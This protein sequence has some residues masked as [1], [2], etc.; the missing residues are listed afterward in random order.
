MTPKRR[1]F[2]QSALAPATH[3]E[4]GMIVSVFVPESFWKNA[5]H[6]V[7][8]GLLDPKPLPWPFRLWWRRPALLLSKIVG[9]KSV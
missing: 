8:V 5:T 2:I 3:G 9:L 7:D 6:P 4:R 1:R